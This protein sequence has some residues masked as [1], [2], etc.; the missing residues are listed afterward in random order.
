MNEKQAAATA[1]NP[2]DR[3]KVTLDA[4]VVKVT[5]KA[6]QLDNQGVVFWVLR[7]EVEQ[8]TH[9]LPTKPGTVITWRDGAYLPQIAQLDAGSMQLGWW[10]Y[11]ADEGRWLNAKSLAAVI[12][13]AEWRVLIPAGDERQAALREAETWI[14]LNIADLS[15][16]EFR[17]ALGLNRGE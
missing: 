1:I 14:G 7:D 3:V 16:F 17:S 4:R 9:A 8:H 13:D 11:H 6:L 5:N 2:G 15:V 10:T 12:G